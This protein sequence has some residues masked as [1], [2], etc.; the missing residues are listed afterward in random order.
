MEKYIWYAAYDSNLYIGRF[1]LYIRGGKAIYVDKEYAGCTNKSLPIKDSIC[2]IEH[3]L[4]FA[5]KAK[6][7]ENK[8]VAFIKSKPGKEKE[9][10]CKIYLITEEQFVEVNQQENGEPP[11][12]QTSR[13]DLDA[14]K[15]QKITYVTSNNNSFQW[16]GKI[17]YIGEKEGYPIYTFTAKWNDDYEDYAAPCVNYLTTI[18]KGLKEGCG[19]DDIQIYEYL[20]GKSGIKDFLP[21]KSLMKLIYNTSISCSKVSG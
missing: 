20:K 14:I 15:H 6:Q 12:F 1:L 16:Y 18:I 13:L 8:S 11:D 2:Y 10:I 3:E 19:L 4:Y 17:L 7:W 5:K 21:E 9:T